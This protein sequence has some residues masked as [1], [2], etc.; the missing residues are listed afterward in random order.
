MILPMYLL[1]QQECIAKE[2]IQAGRV[3]KHSIWHRDGSTSYF[4]IGV[5]GRYSDAQCMFIHCKQMRIHT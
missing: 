2:C 5:T 3:A 4:V 1:G